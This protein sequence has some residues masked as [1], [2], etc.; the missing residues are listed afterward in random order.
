MCIISGKFIWETVVIYGLRKEYKVYSFFIFFKIQIT[1][2]ME[3][4]N[5]DVNKYLLVRISSVISQPT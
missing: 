5:T 2:F 4:N 3:W 1:F